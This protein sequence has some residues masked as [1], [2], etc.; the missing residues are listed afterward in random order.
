[1]IDY[2]ARIA[3]VLLPHLSGRPVTLIRY[4]NGVEGKHFYEKR[5][6]PHHPDW[7]QTTD[8]LGRGARGHDRFH[9]SYEDL[10]TLVWLAQLAALELHPSLSL[11]AAIERPTVL[12]FDLDPGP[13]ATIVECCRVALLLRALFG[14]LGLECFPKSSG[15][16]GM[17]VYVPLN[18]ALN[19]ETTK[20]YARAVAQALERSEPGP[21]RLA[22]DQEAPRRQ[23]LRRL[24][25]E[26]GLEDD[27]RRLLASRASPAR[28][29]RRRCAGTRSRRR[30]TP[31]TPTASASRPPR[32]SSGWSATATCSLPVLELEQELPAGSG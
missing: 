28:R 2:Y 16:K 29:S 11:A 17:Q 26:H 32:C 18:R 25:P 1:M 27:R 12:A 23:G 24:E 31:A 4:P 3:P 9:A 15:S 5:C 22:D 13:P 21:R 10:A 19:Y 14:D 6:P 7:V 8:G 30:S 20:P